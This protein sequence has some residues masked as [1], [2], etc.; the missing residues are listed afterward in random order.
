MSVVAADST[1]R[2][3]GFDEGSIFATLHVQQVFEAPPH[4]QSEE[5]KACCS[6]LSNCANKS[7]AKVSVPKLIERT[8]SRLCCDRRNS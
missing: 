5:M 1:A 8:L 3:L 4:T 7:V 6:Q 2:H